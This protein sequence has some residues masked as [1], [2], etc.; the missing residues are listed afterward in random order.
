MKTFNILIVSLLTIFSFNFAALAHPGR[1]Y[2]PHHHPRPF[3][4]P[5]RPMPPP[6]FYHPG[7]PLPPLVNPFFNNFHFNQFRGTVCFAQ[8]YDGRIFWGGANNTY[9]ATYNA[10]YICAISTGYSCREAG[11]TYF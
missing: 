9:D 11:C 5:P 3:P 4:P 1:H 10:V 6:Y 2:H 8:G 7:N